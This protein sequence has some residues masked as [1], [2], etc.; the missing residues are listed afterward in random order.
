MATRLLLRKRTQPY[1]GRGVYIYSHPQTDLFR[2]I[3]T[4]QCGK[5]SPINVNSTLFGMILI[6]IYI[7]IRII[8]NNVEFIF[9]GKNLDKKIFCRYIY[10]ILKNYAYFFIFI[11]ADLIFFKMLDLHLQTKKSWEISNEHFI[12]YKISFKYKLVSIIYIYIYIYIYLQIYIYIYEER[13]AITCTAK[14][15][16]IFIMGH[17]WEILA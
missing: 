14:L 2:S 10:T 1:G 11:S 15:S 3:R 16:Y 7:Y 8:P 6:Y 4:H 9:M 12:K 17:L 5:F 13:M